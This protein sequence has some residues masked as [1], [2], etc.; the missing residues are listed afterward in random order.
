MKRM[1]LNLEVLH[2]DSSFNNGRI[3]DSF[4]TT[5]LSINTSSIISMSPVRQSIREVN[6]KNADNLKFTEITYAL[7]PTVEKVLVIGDYHNLVERVGTSRRLLN[8]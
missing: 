2:R 6:G 4:R 8:G 5:P 1:M 7:G 3:R